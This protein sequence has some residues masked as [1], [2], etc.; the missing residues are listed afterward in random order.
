MVVPWF[1]AVSILERERFDY[2]VTGEPD[3]RLATNPAG[4]AA[5][6]EQWQAKISGLPVAAE[7]GEIP[8]FIGR[9]S[10]GQ[11]TNEF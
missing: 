6:R 10:G 1:D 11:T 8:M 9:I 2:I 7:F 5:H 4:W 3:L